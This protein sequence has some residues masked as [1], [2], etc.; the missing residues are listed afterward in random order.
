MGYPS[1]RKI[2][3]GKS[4]GSGGAMRTNMISSCCPMDVLLSERTNHSIGSKERMAE[5]SIIF[6]VENYGK[7][8]KE[9]VEL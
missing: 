8:R 2:T 3:K 9:R 1:G 6:H 5:E 4:E 7:K